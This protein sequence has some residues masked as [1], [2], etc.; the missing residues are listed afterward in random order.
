MFLVVSH[1][2]YM[3]IYKIIPNLYPRYNKKSKCGCIWTF[4]E[5][6]PSTAIGSLL[7]VIGAGKTYVSKASAPV[8]TQEE[9]RRTVVQREGYGLVEADTEGNVT[10]N[11]YLESLLPQT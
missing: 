4:I 6:V 2:C 10:G 9:Y 3:Q 5:A 11:T 1:K 7:E 8:V